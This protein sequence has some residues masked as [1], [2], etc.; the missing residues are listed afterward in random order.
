MLRKY[1]Q[2]DESNIAIGP[3]FVYGEEDAP[4]KVIEHSDP[5]SV[6]VGTMWDGSSWVQTENL[7]RAKRDDLLTTIVDPIA[8]NSL[9][10]AE[11]GGPQKL[12]WEAY[13]KSLLNIPQQDGFPTNV[14][15][16]TKPD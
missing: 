16:P 12:A 2:V 11:L 8:G 13:R 4:F 6:E 3:C 5:E 10:W 1:V 15:W 9:R 14:V 7:V